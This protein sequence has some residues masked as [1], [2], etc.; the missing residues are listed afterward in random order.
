MAP[1]QR[2]HKS[3]PLALRTNALV[4]EVEYFRVTDLGEAVWFQ[5]LRHLLVDLGRIRALAIRIL[6]RCH[7]EQAHAESVHVHFFTVTFL[8]VHFW[9]HEFGR[10]LMD[11]VGEVSCDLKN[12]G[13]IA[14]TSLTYHCV[15]STQLHLGRA[16]VS[17][18]D[19]TVCAVDENV[20]TLDVAVDDGRVVSVQIV[21]AFQYLSRPAVVRKGKIK[22]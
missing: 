10:A 22:Y 3:L 2:P 13:T 7:L 1:P 8:L 19:L 12:R 16:H 9:R 14:M 17:D 11:S 18:L 21:Q 15:A 20:I 5:A 4:D 6:S